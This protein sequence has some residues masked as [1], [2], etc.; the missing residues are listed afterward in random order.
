MS[1]FRG[2]IRLNGKRPKDP[3]KNAPLRTFEQVKG[4]PSYAGV[5]EHDT[6]LIDIDDS[7]QAETL[8]KIVKDKGLA[9]QVWKTTRGMH[10]YFT[11]LTR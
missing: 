1:F 8:L 2:Y 3:F 6:V 10:F 7:G 11:N 4:E 9:C 5:L